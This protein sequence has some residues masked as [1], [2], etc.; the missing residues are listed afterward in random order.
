MDGKKAM[1][2]T[3]L[4][5]FSAATD[6]NAVLVAPMTG[7]IYPLPANACIRLLWTIHI[8]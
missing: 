6:S 5:K 2:G 8:G 4:S 3:C 1:Q 7:I